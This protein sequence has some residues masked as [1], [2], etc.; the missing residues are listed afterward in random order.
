MRKKLLK[1]V[2]VAS[3]TGLVYTLGIV[4]GMDYM[5]RKEETA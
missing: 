4:T 1:G 3:L 2:V 5:I